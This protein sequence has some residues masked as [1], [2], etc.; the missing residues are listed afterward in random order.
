MIHPLEVTKIYHH[1]LRR[2]EDEAKRI[3][4]ELEATYV[5]LGSNEKDI[6]DSNL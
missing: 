5:S 6:Q 2:E 3:G 1:A 4:S